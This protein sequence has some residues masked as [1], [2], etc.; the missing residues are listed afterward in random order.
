MDLIGFGDECVKI[1]GRK[2]QSQHKSNKE[3]VEPLKTDCSN[4]AFY[5]T[6]YHCL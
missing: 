2:L 6:L 1:D 5:Q 3:K 4:I